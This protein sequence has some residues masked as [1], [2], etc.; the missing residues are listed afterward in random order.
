M[1]LS[2]SPRPPIS[3]R[4]QSSLDPTN[5]SHMP[6]TSISL[7]PAKNHG[8]ASLQTIYFGQVRRPLEPNALYHS[9]EILH[10]DHLSQENLQQNLYKPSDLGFYTNQFLIFPSWQS[11]IL[12]LREGLQL[13][14]NHQQ[15]WLSPSSHQTV[16]TFE[17]PFS[18]EPY[19]YLRLCLWRLLRNFSPDIDLCLVFP[20]TDKY[21][22]L[23]LP[24]VIFLSSII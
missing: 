3:S 16:N 17:P 12:N 8:Q 15:T 10:C 9:Q 18:I 5:P 23:V 22:K 13:R 20:Q 6:K 11:A 24:L 14:L 21:S 1:K 19:A 2:S 4:L 7:T